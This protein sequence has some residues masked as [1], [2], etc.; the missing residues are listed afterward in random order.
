MAEQL[1]TTIGLANLGNTCFLNVVLQAFKLSPPLANM[2]LLNKIVL[3]EAS[4]KKELLEAFQTLM[5]DF[6]KPTLPPG[7]KPTLA[8]KGFHMHFL[9]TIRDAN[10]D[11]HQYGQQGDAAETIQY[12]LNSL[13]DAMYES[14]HMQVSGK[15]IS[16]EEKAYI[17][18]LKA[19]HGF[20]GKEYSPIIE[21]YNGQTQTSV[22]CGN[23]KAVSTRYEPWLMLK[24]PLPGAEQPPHRATDGATLDDCL[25][26]GFAD[27]FIEDY[28]CDICKVQGKAALQHRISKLPNVIILTFKRFTNS[29]NKVNGLVAW[30]KQAFDFRPWMAF[31]GD[32][33]NKIYTKP[34]YET[35][36]LIE[37]QGSFRGGHY[38]MYSKQPSPSDPSKVVWNEYDD[39]S[40]R[41]ISG[42][43][44][45]SADGV[46]TY[47]AFMTR[48]SCITPMMNTFAEKV[49]LLREANAPA[50][51]PAPQA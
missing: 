32:P 51:A 36:A 24:V 14:V 50:S 19:W 38:R 15:A 35:T 20:F 33:F 44:G 26:L 2:C 39:N 29:M 4:Q 13:H 3:R 40:I 1:A 6:W 23:C 22:V 10:E 47:V 25:K 45:D 12:I 42:L 48:I 46:S 43:P 37:H 34:L 21:H 9:K 49:R 11:W 27:E 18:A 7:A 8:P 28:Q 16:A 17:S 41:E 5:I 31:S 30:D